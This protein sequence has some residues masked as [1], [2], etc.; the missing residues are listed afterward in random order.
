M[1]NPLHLVTT[2]VH[3]SAEISP[4]IR[5][6]HL[7]DP[8]DWE[9]PPFTPGAH[10]DLYLPSGKVRQYSLCNDPAERRR[11][12][13]AVGLSAE[14]RGGSAEI[15]ALRQ[16]DEVLL[17]LP[18]NLFALVEAPRVVMIAG[19]IGITPFM[20]MVR[21]ALREGRD[22]TL[23]YAT[24][25]AELTPFRAELTAC[26]D[27]VRFHHSDIGDRLDLAA[28]IASVGP[29][30]H[31][32][33]CG[34]N[35]LLEAVAA[36]AAPLGMR[37]HAESF[38]ATAPAQTAYEVHLAR[39]GR[40]L[41]VA[42][43]QTMLEALRAAGVEVS[44]SCEAGVCLNCKTRYLSGTPL[45]R[46]LALPDAERATHLTPCVSGCAGSAITLDL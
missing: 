35:R 37:F 11:Y 43:G 8:D 44:A 12:S 18:R 45:H 4:G 21:Q 32:Y 14:G 27:R 2:I 20:P 13:I 25:S 31:L 30:D 15:H 6:L 10:V 17:S 38:G 7:A 39:T 24:S 9:L 23:H 33:C 46:D 26:G 42:A 3:D 29:E 36:L 41:P 1:A 34:P 5:L 28:I 40:T 19:G 22:F 16:G